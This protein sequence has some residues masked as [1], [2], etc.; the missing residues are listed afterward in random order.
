MMEV[1]IEH[2]PY[3]PLTRILVDGEAV[4]DNSSLNYKDRPFQEWVEGLPATLCNECADDEFHITFHGTILDFEDLQAVSADAQKD[5]IKITC[6]HE[7]AKEVKD[8]ESA[9]DEIFSEIKNN[10]YYEELKS[11]DVLKAF[12]IAKG[13][14]FPVNVIATMS[15]GK[16]TLINALLGQKLMPA[17][18]EACTATITE[19]HDKDNADHFVARVF[20]ADGIMLSHPDPLDLPT[21][22]VLNKD[23]RVSKIV[24]DGNIPFVSSEDVSL[25]LVDT[26]GPN[27]ARNDEHRAATF[28]MLSESS[29]PLVLYVLNATQLA[30]N[31]DN[32][33]LNQV[34]E[35]MKVG[36]KQSK[37]R[38]IFVLNKL[39]SFK[40]GEDSVESVIQNAREYLADKG[41]ENP[42]IYPASA[43]TAL[44]IR[45]DFKDVDL[46]FIDPV[47][48]A[49]PNFL[50][51][52]ARISNLNANLHLDEYAPLTPSVNSIILKELAD[53]KASGDIKVE[54]LIHSGIKS[55]EAAISVYVE[56]YA[57][58]AKIR[59]IVDTFSKK[60]ESQK[61]FERTR[62]EIAENQER[63]EEI[64]RNIAII[65]S[66]IADG[67]AAKSFD[68]KIS[69]LDFTKTVK[70]RTDR[71]ISSARTSVREQIESV[72]ERKLSKFEAEG[73]C[74]GFLNY[75]K[76]LQA[77][78]SVDIENEVNAFFDEQGAI[79]IQE[80]TE[81]LKS[82]SNDVPLDSIGINPVKILS[83]ELASANNISSIIKSATDTEKVKV[84]EVWVENTNKKWYKPWTWFQEKG[85]WR[86]V[87]ED[88]EYVKGKELADAFFA[89]LLET[90]YKNQEDINASTK[91]QVAQIKLEFAKK[92][93][94][95]D[96]A[97]NAKLIELEKCASDESAVDKIIEDS[98]A[99]LNWLTDIQNRV[100][101]ILEI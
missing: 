66:K 21:M 51:T 7:P 20:D 25:V 50:A 60:L 89:P 44:E 46:S 33:L 30:I 55:I 57:K 31:D 72:G 16:S 87:Y 68:E 71:I 93:K 6:A 43:L 48:Y 34:A 63:K 82:F 61:S 56:K 39:D 64:K 65:R 29:K 84:D 73:I 19:L 54:A 32:A 58:T 98:T 70:E 26:P 37:D 79:L 18:Q 74:T 75:A 88:R 91:Q 90:F 1:Y 101:A 86:D 8:K 53:A 13:K 95:L 45:S 23:P 2:N 47:N 5:G 85:H 9:I 17:M 81:R 28:R 80:Y 35:T 10:E 24:A 99:R 77:K 69:K 3:R 52:L 100:N 62:R 92:F 59:G 22:E 42:N 12:E 11:P 4:K 27:N 67:K 83:G 40:A 15:S 14:E 96:D 36:G 76:N 49:N 41:I 38:Y 94:Q 78:V 97:L